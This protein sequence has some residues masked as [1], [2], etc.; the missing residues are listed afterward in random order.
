MNVFVLVWLLS[1]FELVTGGPLALEACAERARLVIVVISC[2]LVVFPLDYGLSNHSEPKRNAT[3]HIKRKRRSVTSIMDELG[4]TYVRRA[5]R[6][7]KS[8]FWDLQRLIHPVLVFKK[9]KTKWKQRK[10]AKN[11]AIETSTRLS[12]AI[13]YFAGGR[14]EDIAVVH[15]ISHTEVF[16]SVWDIVDAVN[17]CEA[18]SFSFPESHTEQE[19][20][21]AGFRKRSR[22]GF[23]CIV[24]AI[25]GMLLWLEK[26]SDKECEL[27]QCG[28]KKFFCGRKS[29]FGLNLQACCDSDGCFLGVCLY[30]PGS[31][32]DFLSFSTSSLYKK[33]EQP[34]FLADGLCLFGDSAYVNCRYFAT[35]FKSVSSGVKDDYNFYHSQVS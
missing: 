7:D 12:T 32:Y 8:A 26:P 1:L 5:Y 34:G 4:T 28:A 30:H 2:L 27:A 15:G 25:D 19:K 33:M 3:P 9:R 29:K 31:T 10:G 11:G 6:M 35:P 13:R 22:V 14:P 23:D 16:R 21:A 18:L 17:G 24:G 20:I